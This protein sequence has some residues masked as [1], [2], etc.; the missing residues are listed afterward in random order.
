M[1]AC[2]HSV[3]RV[4]R[5]SLVSVC[6]TGLFGSWRMVMHECSMRVSIMEMCVSMIMKM[7]RT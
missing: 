5:I 6:A 3:N 1:V 4:N 7:I 2:H